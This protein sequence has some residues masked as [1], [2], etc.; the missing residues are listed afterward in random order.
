MGKEEKEI[1]EVFRA[2]NEALTLNEIIVKI[3]RHNHKRAG[4]I[5]NANIFYA[6][7]ARALR[8]LYIN[9]FVFPKASRGLYQF[10]GKWCL[11]TE[12][13]KLVIR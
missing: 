11:N 5:E 12:K 7:Y 13:A 8:S 10:H 2:A 3:L 1:L 4:D 9:G 6:T